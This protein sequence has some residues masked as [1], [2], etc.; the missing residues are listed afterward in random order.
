[1]TQKELTAL[2]HQIATAAHGTTT[3]ND[4]KTL[5]ITHP[6]AVAKIALEIARTYF[7]DWTEDQLYQLEQVAIL[8][9]VVEDTS[10]TLKDLIDYGFSDLVIKS[11]AAITKHPVKG[12]ESYLDYLK[13][14]YAYQYSRISK[15]AD[16]SHNM[17]DLKPGNMLDKYVLAQEY[18]KY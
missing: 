6:R 18:L 5:Y 2:A 15:L 3:R 7:P 4:K 13:R 8:H 12:A 17:S 10:V 14:V 11:V 9:D 1:M 16:L